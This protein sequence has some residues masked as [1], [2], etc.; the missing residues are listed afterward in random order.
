[1]TDRDEP[2]L[3]TTPGIVRTLTRSPPS[4]SWLQRVTWF[5]G[6]ASFELFIHFVILVNLVLVLVSAADADS[7]TG[8]RNNKLSQS[9]NTQTWELV[10]FGVYL[11]EAAA[12]MLHHGRRTYFQ[13]T[14]NRFDFGIVTVSVLG[15]GIEVVGSLTMHGKDGAVDVHIIAVI[16]RCIRLLRVLR[17]S[18]SFRHVSVTMLFVVRKMV[19][20]ISVLLLAMYVFAIVGMAWFANTV[21]VRLPAQLRALEHGQT[22]VAAFRRALPRSCL[23]TCV[24]H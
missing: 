12:K 11:V 16:F 17:I 1:M 22:C 2:L 20:Y 13:A 23:L 9:F 19:R 14:W 21:S 18:E 5:A 3:V 6:T 15:F 8:L 10:F 7:S 24:Y 4:C